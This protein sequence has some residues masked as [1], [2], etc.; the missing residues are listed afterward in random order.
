MSAVVVEQE[1]ESGEVLAQFGEFVAVGADEPSEGGGEQ[2]VV[3]AA[4]PVAEE[5]EHLAEFDGVDGVQ[6][7]V[8]S[9][10][11]WVS[12]WSGCGALGAGVGQAVG[13]GACL[14]DVPG[15]RQAVDDRGAKPWVGERFGPAGE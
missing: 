3:G 10:H 8:V 1:G 13:V 7:Q 12:G 4:E 11:A 15:E 14:E 6:P 2:R 9:G 5:V